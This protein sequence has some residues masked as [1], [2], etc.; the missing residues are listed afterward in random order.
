MKARF[1]QIAAFVKQH[2]S[3]DD[4][5]LNIHSGDS[6]ETRF[7]QNAITQHIAGTTL[8]I[9]LSVAF[10]NRTGVSSVNQTDEAALSA[11]IKQAEDMA[12]LNQPDPE[13]V[14]SASFEA[15]PE[16]QNT[17]DA[18]LNLAPEE[19]VEI[20]KSSI[21]NA[22]KQDATVSGMTEKHHPCMFTATKNGFC[23]YKEYTNFGHSMTIKKEHTE[24]KV[25]FTSKDYAKF[26]LNK[27]LEQLNS[28]IKALKSPQDFDPC[29]IPVIF[30]PPAVWEF[31]MYLG[32]MMYRREADEGLTAFTDQLGK[33]FLGE[34]FTMLSTLANPDIICDP[35]SR[36]SIVS[37]ET[38]WVR[39]GVVE[40][41][42]TRR[43]WA[44][45][46]NLTP[47][48]MF[49]L[50]IPGGENTEQEMMKMVPKGLIVNRLWYIRPVDMKA[51]ELT[52][53]TRDGVL[54]FENG[55]IKH[56]VNNLRFNEIP[57]DATRRILAMGK[58]EIVDSE[59]MLPTMLIDNFNFVD[60][61]SF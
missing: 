3:A 27:E 11:M 24:T 56:A 44:M 49:N 55:E 58:S 53:M 6:H 61:T 16:V 57:H 36:D 9:N 1:E 40:N 29:R 7:A 21:A 42:P 13:Y 23:G 59:V 32:W 39:N 41:M 18:S 15:I 50:Y 38:H 37:K 20:I 60:K 14:E 22:T 46:K 17:S 5:T 33:Q 52:G 47:S 28:Q 45:M 12:K 48:S 19:M 54:Y 25:S 10:G 51:G 4:W 30:R 35:F 26:D 34:K 8:M 43:Y 31:L 2:V